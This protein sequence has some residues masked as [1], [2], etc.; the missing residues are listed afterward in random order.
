MSSQYPGQDYV[1]RPPA[2]GQSNRLIQAL[3]ERR[4]PEEPQSQPPSRQSALF[5]GVF[6]F[7]WYLSNMGCWLGISAGLTF[8]FLVLVFALDQGTSIGMVAMRPLGQCAIIAG[9]LTMGFAV[10]HLRSIFEDTGYGQD[11]VQNWP[12]FDWRNW[13][14]AFLYAVIV[15]GEAAA[16]GYLLGFPPLLGTPLVA[17]AIAFV[18]FPLFMLS[19]LENDSPINP[20][21]PPVLKSLGSLWWAWLIVYLESGAM[22]VGWV[23]VTLIPFAVRAPYLMPFISGPLLA[24]GLMVYARL[25]G[26]LAWLASQEGSSD[27]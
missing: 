24:A 4:V 14:F 27:D 3:S 15:L 17:M 12:P 8:T 11:I 18:L 26:R 20:F 23:I 19:T 2:A 13:V 9:I 21:S 10:A 25:L 6:T 1:N 7:P 16:V 22:L 5:L